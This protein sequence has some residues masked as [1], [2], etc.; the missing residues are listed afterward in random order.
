[1]VRKIG[2]HGK[3]ALPKELRKTM[4]LSEGDSLEFFIEDKF[5]ILRKYEPACIF[6]GEAKN[7]KM[8]KSKNICKSCYEQI[9]NK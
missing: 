6:C 4:N 9:C 3:F 5:L 2:Q 1:M 8:Y 7:I